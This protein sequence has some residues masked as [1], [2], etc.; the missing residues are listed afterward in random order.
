MLISLFWANLE[1]KLVAKIKQII[2]C[3]FLGSFSPKQRQ[4]V[5]RKST[6]QIG[7]CLFFFSDKRWIIIKKKVFPEGLLPV[8]T[9]PGIFPGIAVT[10]LDRIKENPLLLPPKRAKLTKFYSSEIKDTCYTLRPPTRITN[11]IPT[12]PYKT[13][14]ISS[15]DDISILKAYFWKKIVS[16]VFDT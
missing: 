8:R 9:T 7:F 15:P 11:D 16:H 5:L 6:S 14:F 10:Q 4:G 2:V 13:S 3:C 12:P 1:V